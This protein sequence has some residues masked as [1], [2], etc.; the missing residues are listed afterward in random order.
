MISLAG[1]VATKFGGEFVLQPQRNK[2]PGQC[3][4]CQTVQ[5]ERVLQGQGKSGSPTSEK[6]GLDF[7]TKAQA[8]QA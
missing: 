3:S 1:E 8:S 5:T 2:R 7:A 4:V 6:P